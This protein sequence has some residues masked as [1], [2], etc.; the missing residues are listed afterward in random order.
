MN[1]VTNP[2]KRGRKR[3][4]TLL[5]VLISIS[6]ICTFMVSFAAVFPASFR[7]TRKTSQANQAAAFAVSVADELRDKMVGK[8]TNSLYNARTGKY[9]EE[10]CGNSAN[11]AARV[12]LTKGEMMALRFP[13]TEMPQPFTLV[14]NTKDTPNSNNT[15]ILVYTGDRG[16][17]FYNISVTVY[18]TETD[19]NGELQYRSTTIVSGKS[20]NILQS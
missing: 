10:F 2:G 7:L 3:G 13:K 1:A 4:L 5:E 15:G 9:L 17:S 16:R 18:W 6:L 12:P 14:A 19:P 11:H 20:S 8:P